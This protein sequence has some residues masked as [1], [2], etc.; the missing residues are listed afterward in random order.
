[1]FHCIRTKLYWFIVIVNLPGIG[2][3]RTSDTE[4]IFLNGL[5][6]GT[7]RKANDNSKT[8]KKDNKSFLLMIHYKQTYDD[9]IF[10]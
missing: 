5:K 2:M 7:T 1:V 9:N 4:L 6:F 8:W 3:L 10:P